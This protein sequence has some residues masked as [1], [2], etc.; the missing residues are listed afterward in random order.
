ML[1][2]ETLVMRRAVLVFLGILFLVGCLNDYGMHQ[3]RGDT[4]EPLVRTSIFLMASLVAMFATIYGGGLG[5]EVTENG[6]LTL[7]RPVARV[8]YG[9]GVI[10]VDMAA[11]ISAYFLGMVALYL[12]FVLTNG[13]GLIGASMHAPHEHV[14]DWKTFFLPIAF[15]LACYGFVAFLAQIWRKTLIAVAVAWP[16]VIVGYIVAQ[17]NSADTLRWLTIWNPLNYYIPAIN[18]YVNPK[19][20]GY[21]FF[22]H[23]S[24]SWDTAVLLGLFVGYCAMALAR[25]NRAQVV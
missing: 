17:T 20:V 7:M 14:V 4:T 15:A 12:P 2:K 23:L 10:A 6:R 11:I 16:I 19:I 13:L 22:G 24:V 9:L 18:K 8:K 21:G 3:Y 1:Y 25:Y 5:S